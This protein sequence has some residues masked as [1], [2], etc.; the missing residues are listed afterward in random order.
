MDEIFDQIRK[1][2]ECQNAKWGVAFDDKNTANDWSS[3]VTRY[4]GNASFAATPNEWRTQV[5]KV[6]ALAVAALEA[7][8]R[9]GGLPGRH[10]DK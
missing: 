8:D 2:R 5:V 3:Y 9:N 10:Y 4:N 7:F 1:E 6:A